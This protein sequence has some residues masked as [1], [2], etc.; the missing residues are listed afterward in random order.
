MHG[1]AIGYTLQNMRTLTSVAVLLLCAAASHGQETRASV[2]GRV[3]DASGAV[4]PNA[5]VE[6]AN[7]ATGT[8]VSS[9]TNESG[10]YDIPYLLPGAYRVAVHA[11]GFKSFVREGIELRVGDR[12][13]LNFTLEVG[14]IRESVSVTAEAPLLEVST[15]STGRVIGQRQAAELPVMGGNA[16][17]LARLT[18]GV[19]ASERGNGQNPFDSGSGT[20]TITVNGTRTGSSEVTLDG[21]PNMYNNTTAYAPPQ[22]LVQEFKINTA[23]YDA[24]Q[25]HAAGAMINLSIRS[26]TNQLHGTGYLFDSWLRARP[27]FLNRFLYDPTSGPVNERKIQQATPGWLHMRWGA[28][29]TG[30]VM[31]PKLYDGRNRTFWSFGYE[32]VKVR[33]ETTFTGTLPTPEEK[34]GDFS[35]LLALGAAYQIYDPATT[36]PAA[37]AGRF[38]RLPLAGNRIP[39]SR[40]DPIAQKLLSF[41]PEPNT[42]GTADGRQ[43]YFR[44]ATDNRLWGSFLGRVDHN[45]SQRHRAFLRVNSNTWHQETQN[46]PTVA[47]GNVNERP[48]YGLTLDDV[49]VFNPQLLLNVRYGLTY[50]NPS[51]LRTS[52]GFDLLSLGILQKVIS[53]ISSKNNVAGIAF[54]EVVIDGGAFSNLSANGGT[55][56]AGLYQTL[57]GTVTKVMGTHSLRTGGEFRLL[58]E[59]AFNFGNVAPRFE[60]GAAYT[61]GPMDNS[62]GA[63]I[64]QGLASMLFGVP[65]GGRVDLNASQAEQSS[66][67]AFYL[68]DDW[69]VSAKLTVNLGL[70]WEYEGP[71]TERYNRS[72]RGFDATVPNPV[73]AAARVNYAKS[74]IPEVPAS[75]FRAMGGL[76]FA[77]VGGQPRALWGG[78][79]NNFA[80]RVGLA[81]QIAPKTVL[82]SGYGIF[83]DQT[84]IDRQDVNQGGFSQATNIVPTL[85]NGLTF[86]A[87]LSNPFPDGLQ[88]PPGASGG[89]TTFLGRGVSFFPD[90]VVNPYMQRWSLSLQH[91]LPGR[92]L[93]QVSYVGNRGAKLGVATQ[94]DAVP[95]KYLST[96]RVRDQATIDFLSTQVT[97]PFSTLAEFSGTGLA[98]QRVGR[99]QLL[100]PYPQF[101]G[102]SV[103]LPAGY[104]YY[105]S[106]QVEVEKRM[107]RGL[108]FQSSWTWSKFMEAR[109]YLNDTDSR[110]EKVISDQDFTHRI[111]A[112]ALY[113]LPFGTGKPLLGKAPRALD[114]VVGGWQLQGWFEGTTGAALGFGNAIFNGNLSDIPLPVGQRTSDRW[115]NTNA[116]FER[117]SRRALGSNIRFFP[118][119]FG[120][121]RADGINNWDLSLFKTFR[122]RERWNVQFR[123]ESYN[124]LNHVEFASPDTNPTSSAFGT[125]TAER[126]HGQRQV[127]FAWKLLF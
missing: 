85:D 117:D 42:P 29:A 5:R 75:A 3:A 90:R 2:T 10:S 34:R 112:S 78:D 55:S 104:S 31:L 89:L 70:R 82:R 107:V 50:Q 19:T 76:T 116:G 65:T 103:T 126:G 81:Y 88:I 93:T 22:D 53:E 68:Q 33:R 64:G 69:K 86:R 8:L 54:P 83:Y 87:T 105:H 74:P 40:M 51:T 108:M 15:A 59:G 71:T 32:G 72:V 45:F 38:Q 44:I 120:G 115:F 123:M 13:Q 73:D 57:S 106:L 66:F 118:T 23:A 43:N 127:T 94:L 113:E 98:A 35:G 80:P 17:Y 61:R 67:T 9:V 27:W 37:T 1:T 114:Y 41:Y 21:T 95:A 25:G 97:N 109:T 47:D 7:V 28:T 60:F 110:P 100:L 24:S 26:G 56:S 125:I 30:P 58:R 91:E 63:P 14:D 121:V 49:F 92:M 16:F 4:V 52:R 119:R 124:A 102:A 96:A 101:T 84:G 111:I 48:G 11:Q 20:T 122:I 18:A 36:T 39:A 62:T 79:R 12:L 77:G 6:A 99:S 46:M